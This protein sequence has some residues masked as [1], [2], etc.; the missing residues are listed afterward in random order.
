VG[1]HWPATS[2]LARP[3]LLRPRVLL[4]ARCRLS[5]H[6]V[7]SA[8]EVQDCIP[9]IPQLP[10]PFHCDEYDATRNTDQLCALGAHLLRI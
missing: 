10:D 9:K 8:E 2:L 6:P 3:A 7:D 4:L 1:C 5:A